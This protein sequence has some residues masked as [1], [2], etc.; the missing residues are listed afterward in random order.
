MDVLQGLFQFSISE[1]L[2]RNFR[3]FLILSNKLCNDIN[4]S[5]SLSDRGF[6]HIQGLR[7]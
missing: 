5:S 1:V 2:R 6:V 3:E 4:F 7:L